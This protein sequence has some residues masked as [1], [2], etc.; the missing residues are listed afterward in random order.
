MPSFFVSRIRRRDSSTGCFV[1]SNNQF[2]ASASVVKPV[3]IF[4]V[5]GSPSSSNRT[6]C[7]CLGEATLNSCPAAACANLV[8][9]ATSPS[10][11]VANF[12]SPLRS[13][14]IP[15]CSMIAKICAIGSSKSVKSLRTPRSDISVSRDL[16]KVK[17][18]AALD[19]SDCSGLLLSILA[20]SP[21][22]SRWSL[23]SC[24]RTP[25]FTR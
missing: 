4:F 20:P 10:K 6:T 24:V 18:E 15:R 5:F 19:S 8:S 1:F 23:S 9:R 3:L 7:N 21:Q 13:T 16:R 11:N 25:G 2:S 22:R 12:S 14:D 17:S